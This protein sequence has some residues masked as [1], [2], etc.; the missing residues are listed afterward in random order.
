M[1]QVDLNARPLAIKAGEEVTHDHLRQLETRIRQQS[2]FRGGPGIRQTVFPW[3][4]ITN[5]SQLGGTYIPQKFLPSVTAGSEGTFAVTWLRGL[6]AGVEPII[7]RIPI[8]GDPDTG[9]VPV[10]T[11]NPGDF[12]PDGSSN[13]FFRLFLTRA[14]EVSK[15]SP[16]AFPG[17][18]PAAPYQ[19]DKLALTVF[20]DGSIYRELETDQGF[21]PV[22][23]KSNGLFIPCFWSKG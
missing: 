4:T 18:P 10:L 1:N 20:S 5:Y 22:S 8:S 17:I 9:A 21:L 7:D 14:F 13:I 6:I 16:L 12:A 11:V 23:P 15:I 2:V 19:A 3:G